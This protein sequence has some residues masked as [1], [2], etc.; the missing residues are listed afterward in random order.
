VHWNTTT[1]AQSATT[2][3]GQQL[4]QP[5]QSRCTRSVPKT[6]LVG[7]QHVLQPDQKTNQPLYD[8]TNFTTVQS[9]AAPRLQAARVAARRTNKPTAR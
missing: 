2:Q 6:R 5:N 3:P 4:I 7:E 8:S 1:C 9:K